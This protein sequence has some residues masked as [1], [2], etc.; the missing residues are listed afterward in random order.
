MKRQKLTQEQIIAI[1]KE[2]RQWIKMAICAA[3][4]AQGKPVLQLESKPPGKVFGDKKL[5]S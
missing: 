4:Q 2:T 5:E 3:E 1:L